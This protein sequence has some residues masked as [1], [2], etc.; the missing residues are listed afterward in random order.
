MNLVEEIT[1]YIRKQ[2]EE[3]KTQV[4]IAN[5]CN[6]AHSYIQRILHDDNSAGSITIRVF[7]RMFPNA[8]VNLHGDHNTT[9]NGS[10]LAIRNSGG[11]V[12][13]SIDSTKFAQLQSKVIMEEGIPAEY[14]VAFLK[15][16]EE[17]K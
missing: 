12:V 5:E 4:E 16:I 14:K 10:N 8:V 3:G 11:S 15:L 17:T 13:Q 7:C 1:E 9:I 6:I 2:Y